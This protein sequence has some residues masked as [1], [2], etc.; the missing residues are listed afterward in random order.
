VNPA[1]PSSG[2]AP[3]RRLATLL[4]GLIFLALSAET[5]A[6][7]WIGPGGV[8][9]PPP[10]T[11]TYSTNRLDLDADG[12]NDFEITHE[13]AITYSAGF[14]GWQ[15]NTA[16][17]ISLVPLGGCQILVSDVR[18]TLAGDIPILI[19]G[20]AMGTAPAGRHWGSE[21]RVLVN[22]VEPW[23]LSGPLGPIWI[24]A[25]IPAE[26]YIGIRLGTPEA[27]RY[28]WL[29]FTRDRGMQ[30]ASWGFARTASSPVEAGDLGTAAAIA[31]KMSRIQSGAAEWPRLTW[32]PGFANV[33]VEQLVPRD[34]AVWTTV[35]NPSDPTY[36]SPMLD[37]GF[38]VPTGEAR[39]FQVRLAQ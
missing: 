18:D 29:R 8:G 22:R 26:A 2:P 32:E 33:I 6:Q 13:Q 28:G 1:F 31:A 20:D 19:R 25:P 10:S 39:L 3:F 30:P 12:T 36:R 17:L 7:P 35:E 27:P 34:G 9:G 15:A 24:G 16:T 21:S 11:V 14:G 5:W 38:D 37:L 4:A 23:F